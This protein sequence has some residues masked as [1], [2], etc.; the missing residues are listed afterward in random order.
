MNFRTSF[1]K[2]LLMKI[3]G[4]P[5]ERELKQMRP[6]VAQINALEPQFEGLSDE[7]LRAKSGELMRRLQQGETLDD[8]L[9]EAFAA[10]R[11]ASK[12]TIGLRHYDVQL[13]GGM[14]LHRGY[15]VEM[16]TG[17]G[18][19]LVATLPLYLNALSG[20][21]VHLVTVNDYLARRD[22]QWMGPIYD[23]LGLSVGLLQQGDEQSFVFDPEQTRGE[24]DYRFL[25]AVR[26]QEA[27][28]AYITYGTN[29]EFGF[30]YLRDNSARS[31][32]ARAQRGF[33]YAIVDEVDNILID[34]A[35]TPLII[36]GPANEPTD[37]YYKLAQ[38]V[39]QLRPE[40]YDINEKERSITLTDSGY[41]RVEELLGMPL[42]DP[43]NP[44][45]LSPQQAR[46]NHH[47]EQAL[48][49]QFI[50]QR[51]RDYI[52][53][54]KR[55]VIVDEFT[56]RTM[57]GRRW[58]DGLHQAVEA[59]EGVPI[60]QENITYATIT[61][62]NYF[63]MYAKLSGMTGTAA[64]EREEFSKIYNLNVLVLPT[65]R[66]VMRQDV[67]DVI[68]RTQEAKFRAIVQRIVSCHCQGRPVLVGTASVEAS[69]FLGQRLKGEMLRRLAGVL[70]LRDHVNSS[71]IDGDVY[72]EAMQT[73]NQP[74][75]SL[76]AS[77]LRKLSERLEISI[78]LRNGEVVEHLAELF[79][80]DDTRRLLSVLNGE[81]RHSVLNARHHTQE[82][83]IIACAGQLGAVTIATNM[84]GRGVDIKLGGELDEAVLAEVNRVLNQA[85][86][87]PFG[88]SLREKAEALRGLGDNF[89]PIYREAVQRFLQHIENEDRVKALGGLYVLG[90]ERHEARR[91]DNQLRGRAGRQG[92]P[93]ASCFYISMQDELI[94]RFGGARLTGLLDRLGAEDDIPVSLGL[95]SRAIANAQNQVEGYNFDI[96]K[97]LLEYDDVLN[98]QRQVIYEQRER[99]LSKPNLRDDVW[100]MVQAEIGRRLDEVFADAKRDESP[101]L[102]R[103]VAYLERVQP[104][105]PLAEGEVF[106]S[107]ALRYA[108]AAL[109]AGGELQQVRQALN[110]LIAQ[111]LICQR[112]HLYAVSEQAIQQGVAQ[113]QETVKRL[114]EAASVALEGV[115][116]EAR[117]QGGEIDV[118][119]LARAVSEQ[120]GLKVDPSPWRGLRGRRL[121]QAMLG[122][123]RDL[124]R[125]QARLR[126]LVQVTQR[127]GIADLSVE[128]RTLVA[129]DDAD[130]SQAILDL[131]AQTMDRRIE[132]MQSEI[133]A[134]IETH[135]QR[136]ADTA[137]EA[138]LACLQAVRF[139]VRTG[140]DQ[141]HRKVA[142][143]VERFDFIPWM[144][145]QLAGWP[146]ERMEQAILT[147]LSAVIDA[148]AQSWGRLEFQ[149]ISARSLADLEPEVQQGLREY[150]GDQRFS[151]LAGARLTALSE[152]DVDEICAYLGEQVLFNVQRQLML[153]ITGYFWVEHLTAIETLRHGIGL[154][155]YAQKDP[156]SEY[157]VRAYDMF[158]ELLQSIQF[159]VV[160][161]MFTYR[162]R[163]QAQVR[164]G[165]ERKK[166]PDAELSAPADERRKQAGSGRKKPQRPRK[167]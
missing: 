57:S 89:N 68:F 159:Q 136:S 14:A 66:P 9:V 30:D 81:V 46:L 141:R 95:A 102:T 61:L 69:E 3:F 19:T 76:S 65:H 62:Q 108:L 147:H 74:L 22:V 40:D 120:T 114:A 29:S 34:E 155:S 153:E 115:E 125:A 49:A 152:Q 94:K 91:I 143:R 58:S 10:V 41:D 138:L 88:L 71:R 87:A 4:D 127:V 116:M 82:A 98:T 63:R 52:L 105:S 101:D 53:Q 75:E 42:F 112:R 32:E 165:V 37:E 157:K 54:S 8:I 25:R 28:R 2:N 79:E 73:L 110:E 113:C 103:L 117:D 15:V 129:A 77:D 109:P 24:D 106:P 31:L 158:Q 12:R 144:A 80:V 84:A 156:L 145:G 149:R 121:E 38:V 161:A 39:R 36:S 134:E 86:I 154:Q 60:R 17:E 26:R 33:N 21:G 162:P 124:A 148:A 35:R 122:Q 48:K 160:T 97:H 67:Q 47:L 78:D 140:F 166:R 99:I 7:Q 151:Q 44:E 111:A 167:R 55:V 131:V 163:D 18:K 135:I 128:R 43:D 20:K 118:S 142:Q 83:R 123:V 13:L 139:G 150:L 6:L 130:L 85:S 56:G 70:L 93:G 50:F 5:G 100:A 45:E 16:K 51:D 1:F 90:T 137:T 126:L 133:Q 107:F 119:V 27:Y 96:R 132:E 23:A 72:K 64:T 11:E 104:T 92:D 146:R 59:K 164:V